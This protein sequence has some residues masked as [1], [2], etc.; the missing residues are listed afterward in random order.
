MAVFEIILGVLASLPVWFGVARLIKTKKVD[1]FAVSSIMVSE[2]GSWC[3]SIWGFNQGFDRLAILV[4]G[5]ANYLANVILMSVYF[6]YSRKEINVKGLKLSHLHQLILNATFWVSIYIIGALIF[7][8]VPFRSKEFDATM[9]FLAPML[10]AV[11]VSPQIIKTIITK[12]VKNLS[13]IMFLIHQTL[14]TCW[15]TYWAIETSKDASAANIIGLVAQI[16]F[17]IINAIQVFLIIW[18]RYVKKDKDIV[19]SKIEQ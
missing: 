12:D 3:Y 7:S 18:N 2:T 10:I 13:L 1:G 9:S 8:L 6:Y 17:F 16:F 11:A 19:Y 5:A 14:C 15:L 4:S